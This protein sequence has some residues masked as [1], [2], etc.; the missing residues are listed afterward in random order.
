[1]VGKKDEEQWKQRLKEL[2]AY[3]KKHGDCLIP[4]N[5]EQN[6][7]LGYWVSRQRK[8]YKKWLRGVHAKITQDRIDQLNEID[9]V[10]E[11]GSNRRDDTLWRQHF[12]ELVKYKKKHGDC[13]VPNKYE[14]NKQLGNWVGNQRYQYKK[15]L[16]G[17]HTSITQERIDQLNDIDF[18]WD[19]RFER[20]SKESNRSNQE[21]YI[22]SVDHYNVASTKTKSNR[23]RNRRMSS[24]DRPKKRR[25]RQQHSQDVNR[26]LSP[27]ER[28]ERRRFMLQ[29]LYNWRNPMQPDEVTSV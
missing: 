11:V 20:K 16:N 8:E 25:R 15:W 3:K 9:F 7:K 4:Y 22:P 14:H 24:K 17:V 13:L 2:K 1:M 21:S 18:A 5:Y 12:N 19:A 6:P 23:P 27:A 10:W 29:A 26:E 28:K